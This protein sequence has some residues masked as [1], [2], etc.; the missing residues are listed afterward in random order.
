MKKTTIK[1]RQEGNVL[2]V[3]TRSDMVFRPDG[4]SVESSLEETLVTAPQELTDDAQLQA[5]TNIGAYNGFFERLDCKVD[6]QFK[7]RILG[8]YIEGPYIYVTTYD[9]YWGDYIYIYDRKYRMVSRVGHYGM[10]FCIRPYYQYSNKPFIII[11][12]SLYWCIRNPL[13]IKKCNLNGTGVSDFLNVT[14]FDLPIYYTKDSSDNLIIAF[15]S[16][17]RRYNPETGELIN[18]Y[19]IA[20]ATSYTYLDIGETRDGQYLYVNNLQ[21]KQVV[22]LTKEDF[23][24]YWTLDCS[25]FSLQHSIALCLDYDKYIF[26]YGKVYDLTTKS[27]KYDITSVLKS[28]SDVNFL[29][30]RINTSFN[31]FIGY[32][33]NG[34]YRQTYAYVTNTV[35]ITGIPEDVKNL[36]LYGEHLYFVFG[37]GIYRM[38]YS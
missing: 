21:S 37:T 1:D 15:K 14:D 30:F 36:F 7:K 18:E 22:F 23:S 31:T 32:Y 10:A 3:A 16:S 6:M 9:T 12:S 2:A 4:K 19:P 5:R 8:I 24:E 17:I 11:G 34:F 20:G 35:T 26:A 33:Q 29:K 13:I 38:R 28:R 25:D 27:V